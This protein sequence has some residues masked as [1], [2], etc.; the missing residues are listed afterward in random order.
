[1]SIIFALP[2]RLTMMFDGL[3][4]PC[5]ISSRCSAASP[6]RHSRMI[7]TATP[8]LNRVRVSVGVAITR[9]MYSQ[10]LWLTFLRARTSMSGCEQHVEVVAV[11]PFHLLDADAAPLDEI[12][13][14]EQVVV[15]NLGD[16]AGDRRH[17]LHRLAVVPLVGESLG[18]KELERDRQREIVAAAPLAEIDDPLAAG[19]QQPPQSQ[20]LGPPQLRLR[21]EFQIMIVK[22]AIRLLPRRRP[23]RSA[24]GCL[25]VS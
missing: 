23:R 12:L 21:N 14:V 9:L 19:P 18:R 10:R 2:V 25:A 22:F 6:A 8:G 4:S 15:L 5:T 11:D 17:P 24:C 13:H 3:M 1:M 7:D 20:M 16:A